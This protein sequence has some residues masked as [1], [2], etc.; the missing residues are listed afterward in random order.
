MLFRLPL[1]LLYTFFGHNLL[2]GEKV[3]FT[4]YGY[5]YGGRRGIALL[6]TMPKSPDVLLAYDDI[7]IGIQYW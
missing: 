3:N 4:G 5:G 2:R 7:G 1:Q 6:T